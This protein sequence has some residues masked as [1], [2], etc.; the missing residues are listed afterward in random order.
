MGN[1]RFDGKVVG[2][3]DGIGNGNGLVA[4]AGG[5]GGGGC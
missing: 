1:G 3:P 5:G 2:S 4:V